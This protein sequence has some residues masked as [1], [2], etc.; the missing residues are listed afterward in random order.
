MRQVLSAPDAAARKQEGRQLAQLLAA[1]VPDS[2]A[3]ETVYV[4]RV[5]ISKA[6]DDWAANPVDRSLLF[7]LPLDGAATT[8]RRE[9]RPSP[10]EGRSRRDPTDEPLP[11]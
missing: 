5:T 11:E 1:R 8:E 10:A 3:A 9:E 2:I 7:T 6:P 4:Y